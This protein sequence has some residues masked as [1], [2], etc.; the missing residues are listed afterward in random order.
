MDDLL[1]KMGCFLE[2]LTSVVPE[3]LSVKFESYSIFS[4]VLVPFF[5]KSNSMKLFSLGLSIVKNFLLNGNSKVLE[6]TSRVILE[7]E[8]SCASQFN[9]ET[10]SKSFLDILHETL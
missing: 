10:V 6:I 4:Q 9:C 1:L 8:E 7:Y 5:I 3:A 2:T